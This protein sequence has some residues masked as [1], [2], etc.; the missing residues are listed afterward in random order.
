MNK[1]IKEKRKVENNKL[2]ILGKQSEKKPK[3]KK[4]KRKQQTTITK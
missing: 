1:Q 3:S 4:T 2:I